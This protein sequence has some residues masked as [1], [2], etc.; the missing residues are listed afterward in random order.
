MRKPLVAFLSLAVLGTCVFVA[1]Q[2]AGPAKVRLRLV[3][4]ATG[5]S[6]GGIVRVTDADGKQIELPGL[7]DR[8]AG[9]VRDLPGV[10]WYVVPAGGADT[11]LPRGKLRVSALSGLESECVEQ[12]IDLSKAA[13]AELTIR[14]PFL[15]HPEATGLVAGNTHLHLRNFSMEVADNYLRSIPAADGL[16]VLFISYLERDRDDP[17]Y[18]TNKYPIG[19]LLRFAAT[20]VLFNNGEEHRHNFA[21]FGEGYGHVMFLNLKELVRPV[22]SGPGITGAGFD[23]V[24]LR[25]GIDNARKQG[26]TVL[27]CHNTNGFED[28]LCAITGRLDALNV[29]D[30]SR[31]GKYEDNYYRYL[32]LGLH[33]PIST[34]TDWFMYDFSRV[35]AE[36][37]STLTI[38]AWLDAVK[39][40]RCQATN[41]PLLILKVDGKTPGDAIDLPEPRR[42]TIEASAVSRYPIGRLQLVQNG[43]VVRTQQAAAKEPGR[44]QL[45]HEVRVSA[46]A[47]FALR[48]DS[49]ARTEFGKSIF[50]HTSPVYV[51]YRGKGV[52][53]VDAALDLLKQVEEGRAAIEAKGRFSTP[54]AAS[55]VLGMYDDAHKHLRERINARK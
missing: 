46:P 19:D 44:V 7:F 34:G 20:G 2:D 48:I 30:G 31:I 38:P 55:T 24:T 28:V 23:D 26:A 29:F 36:V 33:L 25:P 8:M 51:N 17:T 37:K 32:N 40:G 49:D 5:K 22:S 14:L 11:A 1:A 41:G 15:F 47:W 27:W 52:F 13:P 10:H 35:Y 42:L 21:G 43:K 3:D 6:V 45:A 53:D 12:D 9:L 4:R 50:A 54:A 18:I 39:A 16:R